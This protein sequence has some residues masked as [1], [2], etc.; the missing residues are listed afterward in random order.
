MC[1]RVFTVRVYLKAWVSA[2]EASGAPYN[3]LLVLK[4][5]L[6]YSSIHLAISKSTSRKFSNHL[7]FLSQKL[8]SLAFFDSWVSSSIKRR[9]VSARQNEENQDQNHSKRITVALDS[10]KD[11][12]LEDFVTA[13]SMTLF[14]IMQLPDG[15]LRLIRTCGK[16]ETTTRR[17]QK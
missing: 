4:S 13:K 17:L 1:V 15:F 16:T 11:K 3:D 7:W 6:E 10:F 8:V 2:P 5:L 9:M 14:R 12:K